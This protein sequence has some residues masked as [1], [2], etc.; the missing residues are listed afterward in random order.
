ML[1]G[2]ATCLVLLPSRQHP[3]GERHPLPVVPSREGEPV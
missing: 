3:S 2:A 1:L